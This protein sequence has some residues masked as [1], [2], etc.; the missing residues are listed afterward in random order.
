MLTATELAAMRATQ[1]TAMPDTC[2]ISR[3]TLTPDGAGGQTEGF[4]TVATVACRVG[5]MGNRGEE[6]AIAERMGAVTPYMVTVPT[7]TDVRTQDRIVVGARTF[8]VATV[9]DTE[10]WE[11]A[12]RVACIEVV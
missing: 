8:E 3:P 10:A 4:A 7:T 11:T 9:L 12:R 1:A 2:V 5:P 6:R